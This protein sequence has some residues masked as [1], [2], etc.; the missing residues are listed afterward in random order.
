MSG[1]LDGRVAVVTGAASGIGRAVA[2]AYLAAGAVVHAIDRAEMTRMPGLHAH[3][4]DLTDAAP[5]SEVFAKIEQREGR[6]DILVNNAG[7]IF[8][9]PVEDIAVEAWDRLLAVNLR[10]PFLCVRAV[11]AGMKRRRRGAI[12]NVS[13]N[14]A[15]RGGVQES[16]YCASKFGLEGLSRALA[17][18]FLPYGVSVNTITPGHPVHTA[19]SEITYD[20]AARRIWKEPAELMPAFVHLATQDAEGLND[21]YVSAWALVCSLRDGRVY[22]ED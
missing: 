15:R 19:M 4:L 6:I 11:A 13:S 9:H 14:A 1:A 3:V 8:Y 17:L 18:E 12:I 5:L 10:A 20:E 22:P 2:L 21:R 7:I 16:A